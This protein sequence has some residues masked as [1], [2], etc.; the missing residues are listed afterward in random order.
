[1]CCVAHSRVQNMSVWKSTFGLVNRCNFVRFRPLSTSPTLYG[2]DSP[3]VLITG[4]LGQLG[5]GLAK[6]MR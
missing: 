5:T 6:V 1:M 2:D 3:R 4:G